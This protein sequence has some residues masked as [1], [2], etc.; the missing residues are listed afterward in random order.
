MSPD[1]IFG[2]I[3]RHHHF[4]DD[5]SQKRA[6]IAEI[7]H[8]Q[9]IARGDERLYFFIEFSIPRMGKRADVVL[10]CRDVIFVVEYKVGAQQFDNSAIAQAVDY[11]LDLKNFHEGSHDKVIVPVVVATDAAPE[12]NQFE[13]WRDSV[14]HPVR[15]NRDNLGKVLRM[16]TE[17]FSISE[18]NPQLWAESPYKPTPTIIEAAQA[19]YRGHD[20]K[21]IS[22]SEAGAKN[23]TRT[24]Q[25]VSDI[26]ERAK[27]DRSK[28]IC[29]VTGVPGSGKT[30]AGLSVANDRMRAHDDEH[31]VFLSGNG[32]LVEVLREALARD[33]ISRNQGTGIGDARRHASAFIQNIH[34]FRDEYLRSSGAPIERVAVFDEAQRAWSKEQTSRFMREKRGVSDFSM[35]EPEFLL[36]VMDRHTDWCVVVC[37]IGAGQ[38]INTGEAGI[39]GWLSALHGHYHEW[40]VHLSDRLDHRD[41]ALIA[42]DV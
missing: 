40:D 38:E 15:A 24:A 30:L 4:S 6:W 34:H 27:I 11:S 22:R 8:L 3:V 37:L 28:A 14:S 7:R 36:S 42:G 26:I 12:Q 41:A 9:E 35:S 17:R 20:V 1:E 29:F 31:A 33:E 39:G 19:L 5:E 32:P 2:K 23:L 13:L 10:I 16:L 18:M 21:E 25:Y